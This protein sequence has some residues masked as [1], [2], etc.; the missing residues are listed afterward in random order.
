MSKDK[1]S[2]SV[3]EAREPLVR[4]PIYGVDAEGH[5]KACGEKD[6]WH[7]YHR[8]V[9][10]AVEG[11]R[12]RIAQIVYEA[13]VLAYNGGD[14]A[15][16]D[17]WENL[18]R[19]YPE[20]AEIPRAAADR[21]LAL[22]RSAPAPA[23]EPR[24]IRE[25]LP[26]GGYLI[27]VVGESPL[28]PAP[29]APAPAGEDYTRLRTELERAIEQREIQYSTSGSIMEARQERVDEQRVRPARAALDDFVAALRTK[30]EAARAENGRLQHAA[31]L[32]AKNVPDGVLEEMRDVWGN[33]NVRTIQHWRDKVLALAP[34]AGTRKED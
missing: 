34:D 11:E 33:T 14:P 4:D 12:E 31:R 6:C 23:A 29:E 2:A 19:R 22:L 3:P 25:E 26:G 30:L 24:V 20:H 13:G 18:L 8:A 5:C 1:L 17:T 9:P 28:R 32:L 7:I 10:P 16:A 21:I 15:E 27:D